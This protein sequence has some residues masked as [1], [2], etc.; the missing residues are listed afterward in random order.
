MSYLA[1]FNFSFVPT[2][3]FPSGSSGGFGGQTP[4]SLNPQQGQSRFSIPQQQQQIQDLPLP[5]AILQN[6]QQPQS[7]SSGTGDYYGNP[8]SRDEFVENSFQQTTQTQNFQ[9]YQ[10]LPSQPAG[11]RRRPK[12]RANRTPVAPALSYGPQHV[13]SYQNFN[14]GYQSQPAPPPPQQQ[15]QQQQLHVQHHNLLGHSLVQRVT[16]IEGPIYAKDGHL[17]VVPLY[18]Y[19]AVKNGTLYQIPILWTALSYALGLEIRGEILRGLPCI[20]RLN[21]LFC[22]TAGNTYP[23]DN[24]ERFIDEN[25]AL[26]KRMYGEFVMNDGPAGG[27]T[28]GAGGLGGGGN[29]L[30]RSAREVYEHEVEEFFG[31]S[32]TA[33][34]ANRAENLH[35]DQKNNSTNGGGQTS[36]SRKVRQT[37]NPKNGGP[38]QQPKSNRVDSCESTTEITTPY[39]A[40]NSAGKVRAIAIQQE[41][42][43]KT[44]TKHC[45]G[46]CGCEQKYKWHRL[47]AYDPDNDCRGIFMDWFLFPSC[48]VCRC[49]P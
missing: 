27:E 21:Q 34:F 14:H 32:K 9:T 24:I 13:E 45:A 38:T 4:Y 10:N 42:C 40:A 37:V 48:C 6:Y 25:K 29:A 33:K 16:P 15:A 26:I 49:N 18:S 12:N 19:N 3:T 47:L 35:P 36:H 41:V 22:P 7:Y 30:R 1:P 31:K 39:W 44:S 46:D 5:E 2:A 11:R 20:K 23:L 28:L 17:P 43:A 8:V